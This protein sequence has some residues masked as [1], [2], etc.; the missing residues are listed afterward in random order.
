MSDEEIKGISEILVELKVSMERMAARLEQTCDTMER[1]EASIVRTDSNVN[2]QERRLIVLEQ[3]VP[4]NLN[5]DLAL[6]KDSIGTYKKVL[7]GAIAAI[8]GAWGKMF[9]N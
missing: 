8:L 1:L 4:P 3:N 9:F 5:A 6:M 2:S 7:W